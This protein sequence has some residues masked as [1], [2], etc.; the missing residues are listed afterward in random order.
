MNQVDALT[1][2][3]EYESKQRLK[4][5][6]DGYFIHCLGELFSKIPTKRICELYNFELEYFIKP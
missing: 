6:L 3:L 4:W 2:K 1:E 5:F